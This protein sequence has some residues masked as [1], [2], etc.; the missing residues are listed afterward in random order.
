MIPHLKILHVLI[1]FKVIK[2]EYLPLILWLNLLV[3]LLQ[4]L[5]NHQMNHLYFKFLLWLLDL[6]KHVLI[7]QPIQL[8]HFNLQQ[9]LLNSHQL[10]K[11]HYL[12][13]SH[14]HLTLKKMT[15]QLARFAQL[16]IH[17]PLFLLLL[18][19]LNYFEFPILPQFNLPQIPIQPLF[20]PQFT[21]NLLIHLFTLPLNF[22]SVH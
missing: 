3:H 4:V 14:P 7:K 9:S 20:N 11:F 8:S 15:F 6:S 1:H 5:W 21:L 12:I 19:H 2:F 10:I 16:S 13:F 17:H 18:H 22:K